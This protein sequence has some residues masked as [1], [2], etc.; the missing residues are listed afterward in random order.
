MR[1]RFSLLLL[2]LFTLS[3]SLFS[4]PAAPLVRI[5]RDADLS[6]FPRYEIRNTTPAPLTIVVTSTLEDTRGE[7]RQQ[8][9]STYT[10][11]PGNIDTYP[12]YAPTPADPRTALRDDIALLRTTLTLT[13]VTVSSPASDSPDLSSETGGEAVTSTHTETHSAIVGTPR[14]VARDGDY[15]IGM[16]VHLQRYTAEEQ[17]KLLRLMKAAGVR[18][19]RIEPGFRAREADGTFLM[20]PRYE[21]AQLGAEAFGMNSL[22]ALTFFNPAFHRTGEKAALAH[23]WA[24]AVGEHYKGRVFDYQYGNETNSGWS[25]YGAAAD[26]VAHNRAMALGSLAA[27]PSARPAT[28]AIAEADPH[29]L[30]EMFR[31]GIG[32]WMKAV[33]VHPYCGVPEAGIAK[34]EANRAV[35]GEF[36]GKQEI[37]ATEVGFHYDEGGALNPTTQQ[38][39]LVNGYTREQQADYLARLYLLGRAKGIERIYWYNMYGKND[40]E[41]FWLVDADMNPRPVYHTLAFISTWVND[42]MPLGGTASTEP[43]QKQLFRRADGRVFL[44]AWAL[45]DGVSV[46][47]RLP[48]GDYTVHDTA[49]NRLDMDPSRAI[50]LGERPLLIEGLPASVTSYEHL[51]LLADAMD[52]RNFNHP[53]H[54]WEIAAGETIAVP[55]VVFNGGNAPVTAHPAVVARMPGWTIK[56][57]EAFEVAPGQTVRRDITLTAPANAVPGVEYRFAFAVETAGPARTQPWETRI[58][59]RGAFPYAR[60]FLEKTVPDYPVRRPIDEDATGFGPAEVI[61]RRASSA[62]TPDSID[63]NLTANKWSPDDFV[64]L[65]QHGHWKLRDALHPA[66]QDARVRVALR[67]DEHHLYLAWLVQDDD[68][69]LLDLT[70][71]DWRDADNVRLFLS[72]ESDPEKRTKNISQ[73]D[74]L[75][76]MAPTRQFHDEAPA[77]LVASLG[78]YVRTGY[79]SK[80]RIASRV[81]HGGYLIEAAVPFAAIGHTPASG[82]TLGVNLMSDDC[83]HGFRKS[84]SL[85]ALVNYDYWNSPRALTRLRLAD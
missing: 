73:R 3:P 83:D 25:A 9:A 11:A 21:Q 30:R 5:Q 13:P 12:A 82:D 22:F 51:G 4:A 2:S 36:G 71:R 17:W 28:F 78:G 81:W 67:W 32:P 42:A 10:L 6:Q 60:H 61:A 8:A 63:G 16:N 84:V 7:I 75:V 77:V 29:Y 27:D 15:F 41:T 43:V 18:S 47:L 23:D 52:D 34:L 46:N 50:T 40:P 56:L 38:L 1:S 76:L 48:A 45:R 64:P 70:S 35:I 85:L 33:T 66:D 57:P 62:L 80:I 58:W 49:G 53:L 65:A 69:S 14:P 26:M 54:R 20:D 39:T 74:L 55:C 68:L 31:L 37:W 72:A 79:E 59:L 19:V 44:A 24:K